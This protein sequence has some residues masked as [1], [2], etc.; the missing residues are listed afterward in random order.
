MLFF[1]LLIQDIGFVHHFPYF[2]IHSLQNNKSLNAAL[3]SQTTSQTVSLSW[4]WICF[5]FLNPLPSLSPSRWFIPAQSSR[6]IFILSPQPSLSWWRGKTL[7]FSSLCVENRGCACLL[8]PLRFL[9]S[10]FRSFSAFLHTY[11]ISLQ[12]EGRSHARRRLRPQ[13]RQEVSRPGGGLKTLPGNISN[14]CSKYLSDHEGEVASTR[15]STCQPLCLL[16]APLTHTY[17]TC[18]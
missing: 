8:H 3:F 5:S 1:L 17:C 12:S 2:S 10:L 9:S 6:N 14:S 4:T 18:T 15:V 16:T 13:V 11:S 7:S